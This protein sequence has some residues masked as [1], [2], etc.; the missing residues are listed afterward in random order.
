MIEDSIPEPGVQIGDWLLVWLV[1][2]VGEIVSIS[3]YWLAAV[4]H[5]ADTANVCSDSV[6]V[7]ACAG[8]I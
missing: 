5:H 8:M 7:C 2:N 4:L 3:S 6:N 1:L